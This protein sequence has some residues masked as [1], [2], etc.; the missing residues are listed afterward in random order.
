MNRDEH[1]V[2]RAEKNR[3]R[4]KLNDLRKKPELEDNPKERVKI[5]KGDLVVDDEV[6]DKKHL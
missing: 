6:V 2:Y 1:A 3:L 5:V 4:R